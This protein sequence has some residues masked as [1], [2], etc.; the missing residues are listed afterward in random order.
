MTTEAVGAAPPTERPDHTWVAR[1][2]A[3]VAHV[4]RLY[5]FLLPLRFSFLALAVVGFAFLV[6]DQGHDIIAAMTENEPRHVDVSS[7]PLQRLFFVPLVTFL[8]LQ[9][10][11][12]SRILLQLR[13]PG[14]PA[15]AE[16]PRVTKL[17]PR[18]LGLLAYV[19]LLA[20]LYRVGREY[21]RGGEQPLATLW[22][23]AAC[24]AAAAVAFVVFVIG[25]RRMLEQRGESVTAQKQAGELA[26]STRWVL[27]SSVVVGVVFFLASCLFVQQT[28]T[29][30]S[31]AIVL[32][33]LALWVSFGS[34]LVYLGMRTQVPILTLLLAVALLSS[35]WADNHVVP[36]FDGSAALVAE[37]PTVG[38]AFDRWSARLAAEDPGA[39]PLPVFV[40]ATEGGGIRAA[41][42]TATVLT[43]LDD[44]I[45]G[46]RDHLFAVSGVSGGSVGAAA[47]AALVTRQVDAPGTLPRLRPAAQQMLAH[48]AL[49]P[50]LAA[51]TQQDFVQRFIPYPFLP[52]R[53][54]ALEGGFERA[55]RATI[56]GDDRFA[57]GFLRLLRGREARLP[58]FFLNATAVETGQR[59]IGSNCRFTAG[60]FAYA[61]D[62]FAAAGADLRV[63]T[64][65]HNSARFTY[66]SPAG[67]FLRNPRGYP[68]SPY[69]C[70][71][72][73]RCEHVVDGGY[74]DNSGA[75]TA[76]EIV[77]LIRRRAAQNG[78]AVAPTV[79]VIRYLPK[80]PPAV[81]PERWLNEALSPVRALLSTRGSRAVLAVD[82][83]TPQADA[84]VIEF[85]LIQYPD[86]VPM[87]LGWLLSLH[88]RGAIDVQM[89]KDAKENGPAMARVAALL[90]SVPRVDPIQQ[91]AAAAPPVERMTAGQ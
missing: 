64:T 28:G 78:M 89:G 48:D 6:S 40:V 13:L 74:F 16:F 22:I 26:T 41:Y 5:L 18:V 29:L 34:V 4:K 17:L 27:G 11:Y 72:G 15:A 63:S 55:W 82:Q 38:E 2:S 87:P 56:A 39:G 32:L 81:A 79:L 88:T 65:A 45:P 35:R 47:Y 46:F 58:S 66:I 57:Q 54:R 70:A 23:L 12:W 19:I 24:L 60:D 83:L 7:H 59:M 53:A 52:D 62:P 91:S 80:D 61:L 77:Q 71:P 68:E 21:G 86:T 76:A 37:R 42:W 10:W 51:M 69:A 30:G 67:T 36:T 8:A 20:A 3:L 43:A 31:M 14:V 85:R 25:R 33:A 1:L 90:A 73:K 50:T 84:P 75:I 44:G 49:A 9:I